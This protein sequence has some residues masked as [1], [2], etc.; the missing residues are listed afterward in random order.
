M[1][2]RVAALAMA[3]ALQSAQAETVEQ[4]SAPNR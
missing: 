3:L 1:T 4:A 2:R